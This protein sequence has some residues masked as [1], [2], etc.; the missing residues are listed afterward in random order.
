MPRGGPDEGRD[1]EARY[2]DGRPA[3]GA[4]GFQNSVSDTTRERTQAKRK[5]ASDLACALSEHANLKVFVFLTNVGLTVRDKQALTELAKGKKIDVCVILD[6]EHI[7]VLLDSPDGLSIRYQYLEIPLSDAEQAAFF[8]KWGSDLQSLISHSF[9]AID[10][11]IKRIQFNQEQHRP[12]RQLSF[13][14]KLS[15]P[16]TVKDRPHLRA[17]LCVIPT[18][19]RRAYRRLNLAVT[20]DDGK[21]AP[22]RP[23]VG[24]ALTGA[25][26]ADDPTKPIGTFQSGRSESMT[27]VGA[28]AGYSEWGA[29]G[30]QATLADLDE[31]YFLFLANSRLADLIEKASIVA[32]EYL[33]WEAERDELRIDAPNDT[34]EWPWNLTE[35]EAGDPWRRIM[36]GRGGPF[37]FASDTP[38]RLYPAVPIQRRVTE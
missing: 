3:W 32:N 16:L 6:R 28:S 22:D 9:D 36:P 34:P 23:H 11:D 2:E 15:Q 8:A 26:W 31:N 20:N 21:W 25:F 4:I 19:P 33:L 30:P 13:G 27:Y 35:A 14:L 7:R 12:L 38:H 10:R 1:L 29:P 5:F 17:V 18:S 37:D 24:S